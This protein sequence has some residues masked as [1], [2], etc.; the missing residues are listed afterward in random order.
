MYGCVL[1][2]TWLALIVL[3]GIA[4]GLSLGAKEQV[5]DACNE[6]ST[7]L[8][9]N[10]GDASATLNIGD[11][12]AGSINLIGDLVDAGINN[13]SNF[14]T[15][16]YPQ[17]VMEAKEALGINQFIEADANDYNSESLKI[18]FD[19]YSNIYINEEMCSRNCP[20]KAN[21]AVSSQ[22]TGMKQTELDL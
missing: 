10:L 9:I 14:N 8:S 15:F 4:T 11:S 18:S 21:T 5:E 1:L 19:I 6:F 3:G 20:C 12:A 22:W 16:T 17:Q 7:K 13:N 2:P